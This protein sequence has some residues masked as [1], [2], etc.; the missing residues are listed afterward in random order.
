MTAC[1]RYL[2]L[3]LIS[4]FCV[5]SLFNV[6]FSQ[7]WDSLQDPY[8]ANYTT[9]A[10]QSYPNSPYYRNQIYQ[11]DQSIQNY[12]GYGI[13]TPSYLPP[14]LPVQPPKKNRPWYSRLFK[15]IT[16]HFRPPILQPKKV[17][18]GKARETLALQAPLVRL[19]HGIKHNGMLVI[20]GF[21]LVYV[22]PE[23]QSSPASMTLVQK[24]GTVISFPASEVSKN[25]HTQYASLSQLPEPSDE[26]KRAF[27]KPKKEGQKKSRQKG[28][29]IPLQLA[30]IK[31]SEDGQSLYFLFKQG[32]QEYLSAPLTIEPR[33]SQ[34]LSKMG[35]Q[36]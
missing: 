30:N 28:P 31:I 26:Q 2:F 3:L 20:P 10:Y 22:T 9:P 12:M 7:D 18:K 1:K 13:R 27:E 21:Y 14:Q 35:I 11:N 32:T 23:S 29:Q 5:T 8:E 15:P 25:K 36:Q 34:I 16:K 17:P 33:W 6:G 24:Q 4:L 19:N